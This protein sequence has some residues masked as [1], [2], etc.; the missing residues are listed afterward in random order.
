MLEN[1]GCRSNRRHGNVVE[2]ATINNRD[3]KNNAK[4]S[5]MTLLDVDFE[6]NNKCASLLRLFIGGSW[7]LP[8]LQE[9]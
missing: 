5:S 4:R 3:K 7:H 2:K 1:F 6:S 9:E 8:T